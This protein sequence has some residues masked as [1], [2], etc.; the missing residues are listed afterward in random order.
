[1]ASQVI[2]ETL[3][4]ITDNITSFPSF[5]IST[6]FQI[7]SSFS[8]RFHQFEIVI[9]RVSIENGFIQCDKE[10]FFFLVGKKEIAQPDVVLISS[11][12]LNEDQLRFRRIPVR[13]KAPLPVP[14]QEVSQNEAS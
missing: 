10:C 9:V 2:K 7:D 14:I 3:T 8:I 6:G 1:L 11:Q 4:S 12:D 5:T 13:A